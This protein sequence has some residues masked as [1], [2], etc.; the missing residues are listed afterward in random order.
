MRVVPRFTST[1]DRLILQDLGDSLDVAT[2]Y[3]WLIDDFARPAIELNPD[4]GRWIVDAVRKTRQIQHFR[5]AFGDA[6]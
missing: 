5:E 6:V 3:R 1:P 2:D 4:Q